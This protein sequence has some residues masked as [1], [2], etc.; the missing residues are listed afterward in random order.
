MQHLNVQS[1]DIKLSAYTWGTPPTTG[2]PKQ[3]VLMLHGF[4]DR[5]QLWKA[6]AP[7]F[8]E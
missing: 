7:E 8:I 3:V 6:T 1:G 5:A 2:N 4:P